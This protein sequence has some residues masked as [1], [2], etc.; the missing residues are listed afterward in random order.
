MKCF[1]LFLVFFCACS[2]LVVGVNFVVVILLVDGSVFW[3]SSFV[4]L[5][6]FVEEFDLRFL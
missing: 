4:V 3:S 1:V 5:G 6:F 2:V